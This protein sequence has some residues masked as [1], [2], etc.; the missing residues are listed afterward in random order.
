MASSRPILC[1]AAAAVMALRPLFAAA[2][3][4]PKANGT[5]VIPL[6][7]FFSSPQIASPAVSPDGMHVAFLAP[8]A[9]RMSLVVFDLAKG[10][11]A[12]VARPFDGDI[13]QFFWKGNDRL[14]F[15][16]DPGG[17]ES[18]AAFVAELKSGSVRVIIENWRENREGA[19]FG[20]VVDQLPFDPSYILI[21]GR[22]SH[23]GGD[24][25]LY[26]LNLATAARSSV[27][28]KDPDTEDWVADCAGEVRYRSRH[29]G[30]RTI[31]ESRADAQSLW[32]PICEFDGGSAVAYQPVRFHG[33]SADNRFIYLTRADA[34]GHDALYTYNTANNQWGDPIFKSDTEIESVHLSPKHDRLISVTYGPDGRSEKWFD[35]RIEKIAETL[36]AT[37][38]AKFDVTIMDSDDAEKVFVIAVHADVNGGEYYLLD[39]R[40]K[41][42]LVQLGKKYPLL[43][44]DQLRPMRPIVYAARDGLQIHGYLT[45]PAGAEGKRV[46]LVLLP[47]GGPYGFRDQWGFDAEVQFLASRGYAVLQPN[48]R[49]SGGYGEKFLLAG[50]HE[51]GRKM[52]DDLTDAV[53]WAIDQGIADPRRVCIYGASYGGYA[54]LAGAV[55]TPDLYCCAVNYVGVADL[56]LISNWIN[57]NSDA[58]KAY[59]KDMVGDDK[60]FIDRCSPV[61]FVSQ[62]KIPTLHA[63]GENDRRVK[64]RN[65]TEL[66]RELK[67]YNKTYEFIR[68]D[69]EGH[70]FRNEAARINF[71]R[72]LAAFLDKYL[73]PSTTLTSAP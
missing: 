50:R 30:M 45:L 42:Q 67:K 23:A 10:T 72:H 65:W 8:V 51:W 40:G 12:P 17:R 55:F 48:Y 53:K 4:P 70:G 22:N 43:N 56:S 71:Y 68:E 29:D 44:P 59:F 58:G 69:N 18:Q 26:R 64:I 33:F 7:A 73:A 11:V 66:E 31:L 61:N 2:P 37:F 6:E 57:E 20:A 49:G 25:G 13:A 46:P 54:A 47:H 36:R 1:L 14:V 35:P 19:A 24:I 15:V 16:A 9:G 27:F 38:P 21:Y 39:L 28:G 62:I 63:Y 3:A 5:A 41:T 60:A 34:E 32:K 52:Q